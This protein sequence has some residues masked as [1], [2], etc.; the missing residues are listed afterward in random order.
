[1]TSI[2]P[3]INAVPGTH[4]LVIGV[5]EYVHFDDGGQP[6]PGLLILRVVGCHSP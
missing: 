4:V 1:M 6:E 3:E 2:I 5:S